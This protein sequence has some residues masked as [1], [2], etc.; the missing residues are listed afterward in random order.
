MAEE[1]YDYCR[2]ECGLDIRGL[3]CIPPV[4]AAASLHF[5]LLKKLA[6]IHPRF[7]WYAFRQACGLPAVPH[8]ARIVDWLQHNPE[9]SK[10]LLALL[11]TQI[12]NGRS[13][14]GERMS[15]DVK[16]VI[17]APQTRKKK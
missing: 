8:A 16:V 4:D 10:E 3:M 2:Y 6:D 14:V 5:A 17:E 15:N 9:K 11:K 12:A 1:F 7:A 13:T